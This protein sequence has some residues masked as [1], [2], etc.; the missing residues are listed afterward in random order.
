MNFMKCGMSDITKVRVG[1]LNESLSPRRRTL[2]H[3]PRLP[4]CEGR[5]YANGNAVPKAGLRQREQS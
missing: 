3:E 1:G 4:F 2:H 5:R